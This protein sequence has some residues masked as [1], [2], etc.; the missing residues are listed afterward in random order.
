MAVVGGL[1]VCAGKEA[2]GVGGFSWEGALFVSVSRFSLCRGERIILCI[3]AKDAPAKQVARPTD[4]VVKRMAETVEQ[5]V[6]AEDVQTC[7]FAL[8]LCK[9]KRRRKPTVYNNNNDT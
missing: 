1:L 6:N 4:A 5:A 9:R 7:T 2:C 8:Q 3:R